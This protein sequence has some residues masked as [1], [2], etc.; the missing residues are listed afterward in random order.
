M[1]FTWRSSFFSARKNIARKRRN[2][3]SVA[4]SIL[5]SSF[6]NVKYLPR[7][8]SFFSPQKKIV[9]KRQNYRSESCSTL[10]FRFENGKYLPR[11]NHPRTEFNRTSVHEMNNEAPSDPFQNRNCSRICRRLLAWTVPRWRRTMSPARRPAR[12][13][14]ASCRTRSS[15][16][17]RYPSKTA[18]RT[19]GRA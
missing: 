16:R 4:R 9:R 6:E 5:N 17:R 10:N 3:R 7:T 1:I 14:T 15:A 12:R 11:E 19:S 2:Y 8:K 13:S 18:R